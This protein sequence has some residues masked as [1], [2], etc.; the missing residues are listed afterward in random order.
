MAQDRVCPQL[1][2]ISSGARERKPSV[3]MKAGKASTLTQE[4]VKCWGGIWT[5]IT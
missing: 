5:V 3:L 4:E 1:G 2:Y